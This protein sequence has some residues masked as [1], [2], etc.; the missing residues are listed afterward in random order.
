MGKKFG[1]TLP[2]ILMFGEIKQRGR[3]DINVWDGFFVSTPSLCNFY[4]VT[5]AFIGWC[6]VSVKVHLSLPYIL[7]C[8][9]SPFFL[10]F[11]TGG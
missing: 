6:G 7:W 10:G 4:I 9:L 8:W 1:L 5:F 11:C 3:H 2:D